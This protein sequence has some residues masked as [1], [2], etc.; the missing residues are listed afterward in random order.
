M[1]GRI[2]FDGYLI[3]FGQVASVLAITSTSRDAVGSY[4]R[5]V[6]QI[7]KGIRLDPPRKAVD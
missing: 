5:E 7:L 6:E 3:L 2:H 1:S 4:R